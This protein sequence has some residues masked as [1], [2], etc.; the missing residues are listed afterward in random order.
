MIKKKDLLIEIKLLKEKIEK[1]ENIV[2]F[3]S[4]HLETESKNKK[5]ILLEGKGEN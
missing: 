3:M 4:Q 5:Q 2:S 1:L